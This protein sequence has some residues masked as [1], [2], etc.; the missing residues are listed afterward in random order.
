MS[1]IL[2]TRIILKKS[3][4]IRIVT[5]RRYQKVEAMGFLFGY[6]L[7]NGIKQTK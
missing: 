2:T 1:S 5:H 4:I 7:E 3:Y 6:G